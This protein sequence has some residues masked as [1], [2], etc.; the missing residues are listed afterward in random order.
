MR[1]I[2]AVTRARSGALLLGAPLALALL[3]GACSNVLSQPPAPQGTSPDAKNYCAIV[4]ACQLAPSFGFGEC[5]NEIVRGQIALAPYGGDVG[6]QARYDC[7]KA[8]G[9]DCNKAK[10]C[11]GRVQTNDPRCSNPNVGDPYPTQQRSFCDGN[12]IT[13]CNDMGPGSQ[14]FTCADDFAQQHFGGP[15]CVKNAAASA[16]CGYAPCDPE[17]GLGAACQA[18]TL[19]YCTNAVEQRTAC[20]ALGG[21]CDATANQCAGTCGGST[22]ECN[23]ASLLKD[24][25]GG[26]KLP[27][28]DCSVR[29]GW[30]CRPPPDT[31]TFGCIP[32]HKECVWGAYQATCVDGVKVQF[33]DDGKVSVYDCRDSGAKSCVSSGAAGVNCSL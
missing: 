9:T 24:C 1:T 30:T 6:A 23:G 12:R 3:G 10:Q 7:V 33:C 8:A 22:Y 18:N 28:Y 29:T 13:V 31:T 2:R 21:T 20:S 32:P 11:I 14:T 16:L 17:G 25:A 19:T 4:G 27:L 5:V 15:Y 26:G